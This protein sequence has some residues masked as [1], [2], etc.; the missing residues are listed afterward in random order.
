MKRILFASLL[1]TGVI[2]TATAQ[3]RSTDANKNF[4]ICFVGGQYVVC[5]AN[6]PLTSA[7]TIQEPEKEMPATP[8]VHVGTGIARK[9]HV[10]VSYDDPNAPY[11][12]E[13]SAVNDGVKRN[14]ER[15]INYQ[16]NAV[17]LPANDG[18][19]SNRR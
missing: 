10:G 1:M 4:R 2:T 15:N 5:D 14:D 13:N 17:R 18:G 8:A 12:G 19:L 6:A 3:N 7:G 11:K 16:N 9:S